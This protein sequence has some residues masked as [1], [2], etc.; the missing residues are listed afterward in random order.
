[1]K[2]TK[3]IRKTKKILQEISVL[4]PVYQMLQNE[5]SLL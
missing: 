2:L 4:L 1:M 3:K 5:S